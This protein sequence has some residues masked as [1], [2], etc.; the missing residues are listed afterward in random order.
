VPWPSWLSGGTRDPCPPRL[1][2]PAV[3]MGLMTAQPGGTGV[4]QKLSS[5]SRYMP[6]PS[7]P[8]SPDRPVTLTLMKSASRSSR[9]ARRS[10]PAGSIAISDCGSWFFEPSPSNRVLPR[11]PQ[12]R[13]PPAG[14]R[15]APGAGQRQPWDTA[16]KP[17]NTTP[18]PVNPG[19][20]TPRFAEPVERQ[21]T[22]PAGL[23]QFRRCCQSLASADRKD[24]AMSG[25]SV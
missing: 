5:E 10:K 20:T 14:A 9:W 7:I 21:R 8:P 2:H 17:P 6:R 16:P 1:P 13:A 3:W 4:G 23:S 25:M 24:A 11:R 19:R 12:R 18:P 22:P 15:H